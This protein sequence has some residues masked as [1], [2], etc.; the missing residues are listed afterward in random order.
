MTQLTHP[1]PSPR[2]EPERPRPKQ[3]TPPFRTFGSPC[4]NDAQLPRKP[5]QAAVTHCT[6][7]PPPERAV[8]CTPAAPLAAAAPRSTPVRCRQPSLTL[9]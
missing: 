4:Y 6:A 8:E 7:P 9:A 5:T 1:V 2:Q 3:P